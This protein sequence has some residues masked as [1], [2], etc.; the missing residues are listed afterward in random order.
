MGNSCNPELIKTSKILNEKIKADVL[1]NDKIISPY[2]VFVYAQ[3][4][5]NLDDTKLTACEMEI[6][7]MFKDMSTYTGPDKK[8]LLTSEDKTK[9]KKHFNDLINKLKVKFTDG[10]PFIILL[11]PQNSEPIQQTRDQSENDTEEFFEQPTE[12]SNRTL[13]IIAL[14]VGAILLYVYRDK[15]FKK[16]K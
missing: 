5:L 2:D 11:N 12:F 7:K 10:I 16:L 15:I 9:N 6:K 1:L 4:I 3:N 8:T 14:V 13:F